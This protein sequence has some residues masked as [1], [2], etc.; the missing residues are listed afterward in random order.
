MSKIS[1]YFLPLV[2]ACGYF[3]CQHSVASAD[4]QIKSVSVSDGEMSITGLGFEAYVDQSASLSN[5]LTAA[6]NNFEDAI[7]DTGGF[8]LTPHFPENWEMISGATNK[9]NSNY[10]VSKFYNTGRLGPYSHTVSGSKGQVYSS[11]W[12]MMPQNTQSGKIARLYA[13]NTNVYISSGGMNY[14]IRGYAENIGAQTVWGSPDSFKPDNWHRVEFLNV[15]GGETSVWLDGKLQWS[16]TWLP[17]DTDFNGHTF[18]VGHMIDSADTNPDYLCCGSYNID[19]AYVSYSVARVELCKNQ[20]W[21]DSVFNHCVIQVP[22]S[23]SPDG[24]SI[25]VT[26]NY[27]TFS[28]G[29]TVYI[30]VIDSMGNVSNNGNGYKLIVGEN[31][32]APPNPPGEL[33]AQ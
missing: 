15:A 21:D 18:D 19:D 13:N 6:W 31:T 23:W 16:R 9:T 24:T 32:T 17:V 2:V 20:S 29:E 11:F 33:N 27:G 30:Y 25:V 3:T 22:V 1:H 12:F 26:N 28:A 4:I 7:F 5:F 14:Q 8:Y 10:Y